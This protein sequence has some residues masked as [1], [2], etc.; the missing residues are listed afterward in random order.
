MTVG[1]GDKIMLEDRRILKQAINDN[2]LVIFVGAGASINSGVPLWKE[3]I[4]TIYEKMETISL[5]K[6]EILQIPQIYFNVRGEKEYNELIKNLFKYDD[7]EPNKIHELIV[8]LR[9]CHVI[10]TNFDNFLE[11]AFISNGEFLDVIQKDIDIPYS[12]NNRAIIKM[13]GGF[14]YDNFVFKED[15][16]LNYSKNFAL[17]E[18][19]IKALVAK[20]VVLF[21]GY[22]YNDPDT[23][24]IFNWVKNILG[25]NN[26]RSYFLDAASNYDPYMVSYYRNLGINVI[27][28]SEYLK[29]KFKK[30]NIFDNT[31]KLLEYIINDERETDIANIIYNSLKPFFSM[32]YL[33][34]Q[35]IQS[36]LVNLD[37]LYEFRHLKLGT[38]KTEQFFIALNNQNNT[39]SSNKLY[40]IKDFLSKTIINNAFIY[41]KETHKENTLCIFN[42]PSQADFY[43]DIDNENYVKI[44]KFSDST[45]A[46]GDKLLQLQLQIAYGYYQ[47][48]DYEKCYSILK[49][50]SLTF[51]QQQNYIWY[52]ISEFNRLHVGGLLNW[53]YYLDTNKELEDEIGQID[54]NDILYNN[55]QN[56][57]K[58]N[59]VLK[60]LEGFTLVYKTLSKVL[61]TQDK[62]EKD[63]STN[64]IS[65]TGIANIDLLETDVLDFY[66]Y[67]KFNHL[68]IDSYSEV[69]EIY[70]QYVNAVFCSHSKEKKEYSDGFWGPGEN[71]VLKELSAF[72][73]IVICKNISK[74]DLDE[75]YNTNHVIQ[76]VLSQ[77]AENKL[78]EI[79]TNYMSAINNKILT[80]EIKDKVLVILKILEKV[81][82]S[83]DR[84][85]YVVEQINNLIKQNLF[86]NNEY[87]SINAF[88]V[89][90]FNR[91]KSIFASNLLVQ[92]IHNICTLITFEENLDRTNISSL[93]TLFNNVCFMLHKM[94][95]EEKIDSNSIDAVL[96]ESYMDFA[97]DLYSLASEGNRSKIKKAVIE[98]INIEIFNFE[99]YCEAVTKDVINESKDLEDKLFLL[100]SQKNDQKQSKRKLFPDPFERMLNYCI[101][102]Y[103]NDKLL[104]KERFRPYFNSY[105]EMKFLYD[106]DKFDYSNFDLSW[107]SHASDLL[108]EKIIRNPTAYKKIKKLYRTSINNN[109]YDQDML[110]E[111]LQYFDKSE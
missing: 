92:L 39:N 100:V 88:M 101:N 76:I 55:A 77:D 10:T 19:Y 4:E 56:G 43:N 57:K 20:N 26:Q 52:F 38:N 67:L 33:L 90:I 87:S 31:V 73:I 109:D 51:K 72:D 105:P 86:Q 12:K 70:R 80:H 59:P 111:Y 79:I 3:A 2:K 8:K 36:L 44:K 14:I 48:Q 5:K 69:K 27:Y 17:I 110:N 82:L 21:I 74:K 75:I 32:N 104:D 66:N 94:Y 37:V 40:C 58:E 71:K 83:D 98:N 106:M 108:K 54:L 103:L 50:L 102:L 63:A 61:K 45:I 97:L 16:Y 34:S 96:K 29:D 78:F 81:N 46:E 107:F 42:H 18:M 35:Y 53:R 41:D 15:D 28:A 93:Q 30:D 84:L 24:Q 1:D 11:K 23:K 9:P 22:S 85:S 89:N 7:K 49:K 95:P 13:H 6:D 68:M 47:I 62:I 91:Q 99:L 25:D 64:F 65:G 60:E